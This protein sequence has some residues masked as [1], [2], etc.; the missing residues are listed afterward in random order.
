MLPHFAPQWPLVWPRSASALPEQLPGADLIGPRGGPPLRRARLDRHRAAH[1][2]LRHSFRRL[3]PTRPLGHHLAPAC[4]P[5]QD[6]RRLCPHA[7]DRR[8]GLPA[9]HQLDRPR[10]GPPATLAPLASGRIRA[11]AP[12]ARCLEHGRRNRF[13]HHG[14]Q[15]RGPV[16]T[17][18]FW[19]R[20]RQIRTRRH[21]GRFFLIVNLIKVPSYPSRPHPRLIALFSTL[22]VGDRRRVFAGLRLIRIVPQS[23]FGPCS[24][25]S[26]PSRRSA[27]SAPSSPRPTRPLA[28]AHA[29]QIPR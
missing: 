26:P 17:L 27:R 7:L 28:S 11:R 5:S 25:S 13:H 14:R 22:L 1:A 29:P 24:S 12:V 10:A 3:P 23:A 8:R 16:M 18:Y 4:P 6:Y 20:E 9:R 15:R 2:H 21:H 19:P